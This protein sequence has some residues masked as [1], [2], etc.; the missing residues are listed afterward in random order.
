MLD[1]QLP[2]QDRHDI[3]QSKPN[4]LHRIRA[5]EPSHVH[6]SLC[7]DV[8]SARTSPSESDSIIPADERIS[9]AGG[10]HYNACQKEAKKTDITLSVVY[11]APRWW[12]WSMACPDRF[13]PRI[14]FRHI[15]GKRPRVPSIFFLLYYA[16]SSFTRIAW[17]V[18]CSGIILPDACTNIVMSHCRETEDLSCSQ[19]ARSNRASNVTRL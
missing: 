13:L 10:L 16:G 4:I 6:E 17:T 8:S 3:D 2:D 9:L 11:W 18:P 14:G 15:S 1:T 12:D 19:P 5:I 7:Y